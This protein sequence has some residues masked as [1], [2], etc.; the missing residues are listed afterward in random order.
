[1]SQLALF[2]IQPDV[3]V[4]SKDGKVC[5]RCGYIHCS[6]DAQAVNRFSGRLKFV[7]KHGHIPR[8]TRAE[9]DFDECTWRVSR[10]ILPPP[11]KYKDVEE[12]V[13][14]EKPSVPVAPFPAAEMEIAGRE[15]AWLEFLAQA[16]FSLMVWQIDSSIHDSM[17][18]P[19]VWLSRCCNELLALVNR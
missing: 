15:K 5:S 8:D 16:N 3:T 1:M 14:V 9:A 12:A 13:I 10:N 11:A 18:A 6:D 17:E 19:T 2:E 7:A 4:L